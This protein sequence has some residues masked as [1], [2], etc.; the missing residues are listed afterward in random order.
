MTA[1]DGSKARKTPGYFVILAIPVE[2][3]NASHTNVIGANTDVR[4][5]VPKR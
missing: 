3:S 4:R 5:A 1:L 2:A